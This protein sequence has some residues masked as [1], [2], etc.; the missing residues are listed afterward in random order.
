M[1]GESEDDDKQFDPT[2]KKLDDAR[3][4]GDIAKSND[5]IT[6]AAYGGFLLAAMSVGPAAI[7]GFGSAMRV[8]LDQPT[9]LAH[10]AFSGSQSP[11]MGSVLWS[12]VT[13][14]APLFAGPV[15][16]ALLAVIAQRAFVFAPTKLVPK[17]SRI[18]P[19]S[20]LKNKLGR[21][22][23]FEFAKSFT[24]L[25]IY[26]SVLGLFLSVRFDRMIQA[27]TLSPAMI[28]AEIGRLTLSLLLIVLAIA[29]AIGAVDFLWQHA[30]HH[31][32]NRMSRK[33]LMDEL[34]Q[35][36]G[37]PMMKQQRR[38]RGMDLATNKMLA[39][40]PTADVVIV[41]P[42]H[43]AV[44]LTWSRMPGAAPVCVAKGVDEIAARMRE[45]AMEHAVPI[46]TDPPTARAIHATVELGQEIAVEY[47]QPVAAA[48]R[49]ADSMRKRASAI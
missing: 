20:G 10:A 19:I 16:L 30:Q 9:S 3:A 4:K 31:R 14:I 42:T 49:F 15:A 7:V 29:I 41:N 8:L 5:L 26:S 18:S 11:L 39:D 45:I 1:S 34:K 12:A 27:M 36:E 35:S 32:K 22:G 38:Q 28:A 47:Y 44:A 21:E 2:Q 43:Y 23:L 24:K 48:I 6:A 40:V 25:G 37:D 46:H 17:G 13:N 33:E